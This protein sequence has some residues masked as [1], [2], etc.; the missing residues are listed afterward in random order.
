MLQKTVD[1]RVSGK[2]FYKGAPSSR[3]FLASLEERLHRLEVR[4]E[5]GE[6]VTGDVLSGPF[7]PELTSVASEYGRRVVAFRA[8]F[9]RPGGGEASRLYRVAD[10][11]AAYRV[12]HA[13]RV[14]DRH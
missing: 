5:V 12:D 9:V 14:S 3:V 2:A 8:G 1:G 4:Y 13:G 7:A 10:T 6:S 11:L